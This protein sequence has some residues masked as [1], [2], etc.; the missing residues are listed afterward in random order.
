VIALCGHAR[1]CTEIHRRR[2]LRYSFGER[3]KPNLPHRADSAEE[4]LTLFCA[5]ET[6]EDRPA[7][8][9]VD[10]ALHVASAYGNSAPSTGSISPR[11]GRG[12]RG[13]ALENSASR[14]AS[15]PDDRSLR[16]RCPHA[17]RDAMRSLG[18]FTLRGVGAPKSFRLQQGGR[19]LWRRTL[20]PGGEKVRE[21]PDEALFNT[22]HLRLPSPNLSAPR[23]ARDDGG[24]GA[25]FGDARD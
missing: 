19:N 25:K 15:Y 24:R 7:F 8:A 23:Q 1:A 3:T 5:R 12:Q 9:D 20:L 4:A 2:V 16:Q 13:G 17:L 6:R 14:S 10:I 21:A 11:S 18:T 22:L